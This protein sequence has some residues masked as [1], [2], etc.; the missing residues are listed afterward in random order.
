MLRVSL[1]FKT[2]LNGSRTYTG[3]GACVLLPLLP[4][5]TVVRILIVGG[6]T[7]LNPKLR[8]VFHCLTHHFR[9]ISFHGYFASSLTELRARKHD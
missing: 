4:N 7:S 9:D 8:Y 2:N 5:E 3:Q 6:S 1:V